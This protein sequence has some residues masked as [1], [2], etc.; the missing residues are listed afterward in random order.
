[1]KQV[2]QSRRTGKLALKDVPAPKVRSGHLLVRTRASL[3]SAGTEWMVIDSAR[4]NLAAK[5]QARP[6][7]VKK[8]LDKLKTGAPET[9]AGR[10]VLIGG[11]VER[12]RGFV[13]DTDDWLIDLQPAPSQ[14]DIDRGLEQIVPDGP[15]FLHDIA[16]GD[17]LSKGLLQGA[18]LISDHI[19]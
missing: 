11:P 6:D 5:A 17:Q 18:F 1:M 8:V 7:L 13:L 4:K 14:E 12:E 10:Q 3:I 16:F 9:A 15:T 19:G 2:I